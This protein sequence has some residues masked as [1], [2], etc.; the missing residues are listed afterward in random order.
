MLKHTFKLL[1]IALVLS[2]SVVAR[3]VPVQFS[4][5]LSGPN[6]SP[7]NASLGTGFAVVTYDATTHMLQV[8]VTFSGLTGSTTASHIHAAT[9]TPGAGT[10]GVATTTPTFA[11]FPLGVTSGSY[12][13]IL[14]LT[15]LSSYNPAYVTANGGTV[16]SAEAALMGAMFQGETYLNIHTTSFPGGEI[17]GFLTQVPDGASTALLLM[18]AC[19]SVVAFTRLQRF[20]GNAAC[21]T[22]A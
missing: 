20:D 21:K 7:A 22:S 13:N 12:F 11:G 14:D 18:L 2:V 10:A 4:A 9:P 1:A 19:G 8:Q 17:R 16:A 5:A 6:E 3:A 15:L